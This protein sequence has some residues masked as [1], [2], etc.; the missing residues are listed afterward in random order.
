MQ[1]FNWSIVLHETKGVCVCVTEAHVCLYMATLSIHRVPCNHFKSCLF[2]C[3]SVDL[4]NK[5][6]DLEL[7][8]KQWYELW[9]QN[10]ESWV[11]IPAWLCQQS[12]SPP[13]GCDANLP[14]HLFLPIFHVRGLF[15]GSPSFVSLGKMSL[16]YFC[17][18]LHAVHK[19]YHLTDS[20][21]AYFFCLTC[22]GFIT[23]ALQPILA[24]LGLWECR[25]EGISAFV[26]VSA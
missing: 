19:D 23:Q 4:G 25:S 14:S 13:T 26:T 9:P 10:G 24:L 3:L 20:S 15:P 18:D 21:F 17:L 11:R 6:L 22:S 1:I 5:K 8:L 7:V 12:L 2:L 16:V